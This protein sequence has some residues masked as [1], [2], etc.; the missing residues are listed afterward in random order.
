MLVLD[1]HKSHKSARFQEYCIANNIIT[2]CLLPHLSYLTQL[3]DIR[4]FSVLKHIYRYQIKF[5]IKAYI[6]YITK[7][8]F[9]L[10]FHVAYNQLITIENTKTRFRRTSL[11]PFNPQVVISKLDIRLR[12]PTPP[13]PFS[14]NTNP[15]VS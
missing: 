15:W 7:I 10:V 14:I 11:I 2:L 12:T 3:L 4:C 5:F 13:R 1:G 6:N 8:E 9:F